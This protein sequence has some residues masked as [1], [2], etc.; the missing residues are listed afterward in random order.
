MS[1]SPVTHAGYTA[2]G[3]TTPP[4]QVYAT[5]PAS[6][7]EP[8]APVELRS[9]VRQP[10]SAT[11]SDQLKNAVDRANEVVQSMTSD[12][13]FSIDEATGIHV[14][15]VVD[16]KTK[17][18]IRQYPTEEMIDLAKSLDKLRGLIIRQKA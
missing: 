6:S 15:K 5:V 14:V 10:D 4:T 1:I 9:A 16:I 13:R 3:T 7:S 8:S 18:V 2:A 12:L 11:K 17:D